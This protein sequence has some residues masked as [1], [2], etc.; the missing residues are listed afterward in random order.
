MLFRGRKL[1]RFQTGGVVEKPESRITQLP[2][3]TQKI[4]N[5]IKDIPIK[6]IQVFREPLNKVLQLLINLA[7]GGID[8]IEKKFGYDNLY[9]LG[10][11][12]ELENGGKYLI[13]KNQNILIKKSGIPARSETMNIRL[14]GRK[15]TLDYLF[16]R[17]IISLGPSDFYNYNLA[18]TN[19][20][21]FIKNVLSK[22]GLLNPTSKAFIEQDIS[23]I[24]EN[25][26]SRIKDTSKLI[27]DV[28]S[29]IDKFTQLVS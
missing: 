17:A 20:Q 13:E 29:I 10:M 21:H 22:S 8:K 12:V 19:C 3:N 16:D 27:T 9:H 1:R 24:V 6:S 18:S 23:D 26:P 25:I 15:I 14:E 7:S 11:V 28:A 2:S 5:S 4:Y